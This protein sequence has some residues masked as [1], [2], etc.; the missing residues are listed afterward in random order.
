MVLF[1]SSGIGNGVIQF[2]SDFIE[3][4]LVPFAVCG[5]ILLQ[6]FD[7]FGA[8][9]IAGRGIKWSGRVPKMQQEP[10]FETGN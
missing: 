3:N 10:E 2:L 1:D 9:R 6:F 7:N 8:N 5:Q 4:T